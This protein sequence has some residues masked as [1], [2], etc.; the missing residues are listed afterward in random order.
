MVS[1]LI[2]RPF[3][4]S[5]ET[6]ML[7]AGAG[8][9]PLPVGHRGFPAVRGQRDGAL[10]ERLHAHVDGLERLST[11][12][13][14]VSHTGVLVRPRI[15]RFEVSFDVYRGFGARYAIDARRT[16]YKEADLQRKGT[17]KARRH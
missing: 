16:F 4:P 11:R 7:R 13:R 6:A 14:E 9:G 10:L 17:G 8:L 5:R 15:A 3:G 1:I 2:L 12:S